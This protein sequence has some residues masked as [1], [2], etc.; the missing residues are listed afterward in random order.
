MLEKQS[1]SWLVERLLELS[2]VD[3]ANTDRILLSLSAEQSSEEKVIADFRAQIDKAVAEIEDHGPGTWRSYLPSEAF[4]TVADALT[5]LLSKNMINAVLQTTEYALVKLD[6]IFELQDECE[7][8]YLVDAFRHL[9]LEACQRSA[10]DVCTLGARLAEL[11]KQT[12]WGFFD[13]PPAGYAHILG[14][15]GL[16]AYIAKLEP[17]KSRKK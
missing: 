16:A 1:K 10:P 8:E 9:H 3:S 14:Q 2:G 11:S 6:S 5:I 15:D 17:E 7:L 4:D 13:G 12:E